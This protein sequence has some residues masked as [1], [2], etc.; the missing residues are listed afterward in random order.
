MIIITE[1]DRQR[2]RDTMKRIRTVRYGSKNSK[3]KG[4][5]VGITSLHLWVSRYK[6]KP[7]KC[8]DCGTSDPI[9]RYEW[10]NISKKYKRDLNDYK[11]LCVSCHRKFD[12]HYG[13]FRSNAKLCNNT[14]MEIR[15]L[16]KPRE[17][18]QKKL[19]K[20]YSVCVTTIANILNRKKW[21][22]I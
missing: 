16:Y 22:Y 15:K 8:E 18:T 10:A 21:R 1:E 9:I 14:V 4:D 19:A 7:K 2:R 13:E 3:W 12:R 6:G 17:I 11:R 20:K 5:S